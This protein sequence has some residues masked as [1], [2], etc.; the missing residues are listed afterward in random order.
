MHSDAAFTHTQ[1]MKKT[2]SSAQ[3]LSFGEIHNKLVTKLK[4]RYFLKKGQVNM[5]LLY[6]IYT[7]KRQ[8]FMH[9]STFQPGAGSQGAS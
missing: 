8:P 1:D 9:L 2:Q 5:T 7:T 3:N 6:K 4:H